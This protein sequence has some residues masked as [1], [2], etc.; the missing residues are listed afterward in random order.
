MIKSVRV[1]ASLYDHS[2]E[3]LIEAS[4]QI[5]EAGRP[6]LIL[7]KSKMEWNIQAR[8]TTDSLGRRFWES[9]IFLRNCTLVPPVHLLGRYA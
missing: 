3:A 9:N 5:E 1:S 6:E 4:R 7:A 8:L 2:G